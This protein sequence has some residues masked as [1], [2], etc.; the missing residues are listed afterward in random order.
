MMIVVSNAN[1]ASAT[2]EFVLIYPMNIKNIFLF[3]A[4]SLTSL[5]Q[6]E[7][8]TILGFLGLMNVDLKA[9]TSSSID[10]FVRGVLSTNS[11]SRKNSKR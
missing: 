4:P 6:Q 1:V 8:D 10:I 3:A 9:G 2:I 5:Q 7:M 11:L